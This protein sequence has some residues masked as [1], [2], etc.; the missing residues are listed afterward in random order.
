MLK[1]I[2]DSMGKKAGRFGKTLVLG[3]SFK[4]AYDRVEESKR[5]VNC[6]IL[7]NML[8]IHLSHASVDDSLQSGKFPIVGLKTIR[9]AMELRADAALMFLNDYEKQCGDNNISF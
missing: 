5:E 2:K 7:R 3:D 9:E 6:S 1:N 4:V 8:A